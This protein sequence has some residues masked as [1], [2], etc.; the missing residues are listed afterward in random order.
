MH[1][2]NEEW[3]DLEFA[4]L[5]CRQKSQGEQVRKIIKHPGLPFP[6]PPWRKVWES[7]H[8]SLKYYYFSAHREPRLVGGDIPCSGRV[9]VKHGDTWGTVCDSDF[10]LEAAG[11]LCRELQCGTVISILGGAHFGE[12]KGQIWAEE[13]Q[14]E[15]HE[16]HLSLCSVAPRPD[17]TCGHSRDVGVVCSSETQRTCS[18]CSHP[19]K[20][21]GGGHHRHLFKS[22]VSFQDTRRSAWW[23]ASPRVREEW[24]SRYLGPGDPSATL[25][26]T[27]KMPTFFASSSNV[28]LPFLPQEEHILGKE[29][30]K[31]GGTCFTAR[32]PS[33][34]W[35][36][37]L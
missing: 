17:G 26:G 16:S 2:S 37:V 6:S 29:V 36:I 15:G 11:V 21:V 19:A 3:G 27:W 8:F 14:C 12:G 20:G 13:F 33:S 7:C 1:W 5:N 30:V 32:G 22:P 9:E 34:T 18:I 28:E 31:S 23:T 10:S 25:T 24:S 4:M 35:E